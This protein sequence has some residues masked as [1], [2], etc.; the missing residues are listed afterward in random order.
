[1]GFDDRK[2]SVKLQR[3]A[4]EGR[5]LHKAL[6]RRRVRSGKLLQ[7]IIRRQIRSLK[8][9]REYVWAIDMTCP[10]RTAAM[11]YLVSLPDGDTASLAVTASRRAT[12]NC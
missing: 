1:M 2:K 5:P 4:V 12:C 11:L 10:T 6:V 7:N 3:P 9:V 8:R